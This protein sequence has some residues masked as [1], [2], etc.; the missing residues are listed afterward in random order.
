MDTLLGTSASY[1]HISSLTFTCF[2]IQEMES[3]YKF[4]IDSIPQQRMIHY[5]VNHIEIPEVQR[6]LHENDGKVN[7]H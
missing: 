2:L 6:L 3:Q 7:R 4:R 5:A 1:G